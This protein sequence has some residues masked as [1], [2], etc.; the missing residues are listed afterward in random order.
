MSRDHS[1]S[2]KHRKAL[3]AREPRKVIIYVEGRNTEFSYCE[4]LKSQ[5]CSLIPVVQRGHGIGKCV[6]FV[7]E[8]NKKF[9][10]LSQEQRGKYKQK[11]LMYDS[12]GH[13]D[14]AESVVKAR[15][16]GFKVV[17]SNMCIEYWFV[18]HFYKHDGG[19]I[20][21]KADSHSQAQI[22]MI[23]DYIIRYNRKA[24][25]KVKEYD[26]GSKKVEDD[27]FELMLA[28][29]PQTHHRRILDAYARAKVIHTRKK[30]DGAEFCESVTTMYEFLKEIGVVKEKGDGSITLA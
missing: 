29:D 30:A 11:W 2:Y 26:V 25:L 28:F 8:S 9:N 1:H 22:D 4:Q 14:F 19:A 24:E 17:F 10:N 3:D 20:P 12:D 5:N 7:E 6:D 18:L 15:E 13:D 16:Y 21:M 27:F 23:N